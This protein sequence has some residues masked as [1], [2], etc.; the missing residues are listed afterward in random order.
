LMEYGFS[1]GI[2]KRLLKTH[3][4]DV[5][6]NA[7]KAVNVQIERNHVKNAK[8]MLQTAIKEKWHPEVFKKR[9]KL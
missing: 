9:K 6:K 5:I 2:A 8:A 7:I 4:E 1:K 3:E